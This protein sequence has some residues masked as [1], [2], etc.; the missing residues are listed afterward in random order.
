MAEYRNIKFATDLVT[1]YASSFWGASGTMDDLRSLVTS[2]TWDPL[3][4]WERILD[5]SKEA[6][7]DCIEI[8]FVPSTARRC[9]DQ[10]ICISL[11]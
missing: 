10:L 11:P 8:T 5:S 6:G 7:L 9:A 1:Y 4:F 2:G 3:R